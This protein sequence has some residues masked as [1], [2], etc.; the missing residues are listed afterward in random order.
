MVATLLAGQILQLF[1]IM[2]LGYAVVRTGL[3]RTQDS[4]T[5]SVLIVYIILPCTILNAFQIAYTDETASDFLLAVASAVIIHVLLFVILALISRPLRLNSIEK[6]SIIY[7]NAGNLILPLV[8]AILGEEWVLFA[9]A[10]M[11]VQLFI[12]WTHGKSLIEEKRGAD[13]RSIITNVNLL[14]CIAGLLL[15]LLHIR[16]PAMLSGTIRTLGSAIGPLTMLTLG[17]ILAGIDLKPVLRGKRIWLIAFLRMIAVPAA[18]LLIMKTSGI[19]KLSPNGITILYIS[20]LATMTPSATTVTQMAQLYGKDYNYAT[21]IN[22]LTTLL[23]IATMPLMTML[24][25]L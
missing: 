18:V 24:Y 14:A 20:L 25:Y 19:A 1:M 5:L 13:F 6:A 2:F 8:T 10:F 16:L 21:A 15:F 11:V 9:S 17:M 4:R 7:S 12:I 23:C 3:L 22:T